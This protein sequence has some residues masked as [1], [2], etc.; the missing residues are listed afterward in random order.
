MIDIKLLRENPDKFEKAAK[1]KNAKIDIKA[2]L[3][4]DEEKRNLQQ[5]VEELRAEQNKANDGIAAAEGPAKR[6]KIM[7]MKKIALE[8]KDLQ[9]LYRKKSEEA[10]LLLYQVPNPAAEDVPVAKDESGN[11]LMH[12]FGE[13]PK[14]DF[15]T[16]SYLDIVPDEIDTESAAKVSG[17]RF[18]YLK[19]D[20]VKLEFAL[21]RYAM[22]VISE[23]GFT[24]VVPPVL[25]KEKAMRAMG[26]M[27]RGE[28]EIYRTDED[29]LYLIGTSEQAVGPMHMDEIFSEKQLPLRY[30]AFSPCFRREAGSYGKDTKGILRVH[31]FD[32]VEMFS[33]TRPEHSDKEHELLLSLQ[34][35]LMQGLNLHYQV[36]KI[37]TGDLGDP[38][39]RKFDIETWIPS[40]NKY[41]ETHSTSTCTDFQARR[42]NT[43]FK[44]DGN[45][46]FV[47]TLNG[48][49]F[50]IGRTLIAIIE[51]YQRED[52]SF[53]V[54][55][56]LR[57]YL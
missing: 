8:V 18:G 47:H 33:F 53:V 30:V 9:G 4:A 52:G 23:E 29:S 41:R 3:R 15:K 10:D 16:K 22:D 1:D 36:V 25:I 42:L 54:P 38:A 20:L 5:K 17:T 21:V 56:V 31:Q 48:T 35:K 44:K 34:E 55:E 32:K 46:E 14:F 43:R 6:E 2:I 13:K 37:C 57:K 11:E 27:D 45:N 24:P 12:K 50:A 40:E 51:N 26:Y 39:A 19:G 28:D 49:A 7:L